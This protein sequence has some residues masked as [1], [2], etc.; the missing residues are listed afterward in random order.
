MDGILVSH[1]PDI[2]YLTGYSGSNALALVT[3]TQRILVTDVRYEYQAPSESPGWELLIAKNSTLAE[4]LEYS[5]AIKN[6]RVLGYDENHVSVAQF[7]IFRSLFQSVK[8]KRSADVLSKLRAVKL[9]EEVRLLKQA[10]AMA[11]H[12]YEE[13]LPYIS[14]GVREC[15]IAAEIRYRAARSGSEGDPFDP[16]VVSGPR[17]AL[18]HGKPSKRKVYFA[19]AY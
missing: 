16:I 13:V 19:K 5:D 7:S 3:P 1:L 12:I 10:A 11:D 8:F 9:P 14:T 17:S 4:T 2:R 18:I 6:Y 15:D